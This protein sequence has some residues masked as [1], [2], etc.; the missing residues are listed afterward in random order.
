MWMRLAVASMDQVCTDLACRPQEASLRESNGAV[1]ETNMNGMGYIFHAAKKKECWQF[2]NEDMWFARDTRCPIARR[3]SAIAT[4]TR[5]AKQ[6]FEEWQM[7]RQYI[8]F[9]VRKASADLEQEH[10]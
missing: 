8:D 4:A 9:A 2:V 3:S 1:Y 10:V 6:S 5:P 7:Q